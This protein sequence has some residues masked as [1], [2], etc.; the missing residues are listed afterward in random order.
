M[1]S[2][3]RHHARVRYS[4]LFHLQRIQCEHSSAVSVRA[5]SKYK[6]NQQINYGRIEG[7][8]ATKE[9]CHPVHRQPYHN[10]TTL[11]T[12]IFMNQGTRQKMSHD[13]VYAVPQL[14]HQQSLGALPAHIRLSCFCNTNHY[15]FYLYISQLQLNLKGRT[16]IGSR[17]SH[18]N[19]I[20]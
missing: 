9:G 12:T 14:H 1:Y 8:L 20:L 7:C 16:T 6:T 3:K 10:H 15:V 2:S 11:G 17:Q 18:I 19:H 5:L 13:P 4:G